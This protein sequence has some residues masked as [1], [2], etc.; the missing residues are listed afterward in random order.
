MKFSFIMIVLNGM[1]FIEVALKSIYNKAYE[2]I[3]VEGAVE[4]C[5]FAAN[6]DGSSKDGTVEFIK[7]FPDPENK[8]KL[9]Q[10]AWPEKCEMQNRALEGATGDYIW[11]IDSDEVYKEEDIDTVNKL[12]E[13]DPTITQINFFV[14]H[15]WRGFDYIISSEILKRDAYGFPRLFKLERPCRYTTH[16]PPTLFLNGRGKHTNGLNLIKSSILKEIGV[17]LYHYSY[18][19]EEQVRQKITLYKHYGWGKSWGLDLDEWL[20][21]CFL[22]WTPENRDAIERKYPI[23]TGDKDSVTERFLGSHPKVITEMKQCLK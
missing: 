23:W 7:A 12:L 4:K 13:D 16:R 9:I 8:I 11:L 3:I 21:N 15:F 22:A 2:I 18:V 10:G 5:M 19:L 1:P 20:T 14:I 17:Y 6:P